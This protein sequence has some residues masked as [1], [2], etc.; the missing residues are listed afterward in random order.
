MSSAGGVFSQIVSAPLYAVPPLLETTPPLAAPGSTP[1]E[2]T[3]IPSQ[4]AKGNLGG[5]NV[6]AGIGVTT[7]NVA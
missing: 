4:L 3:G 5:P 6:S 1:G 7:D 2:Q